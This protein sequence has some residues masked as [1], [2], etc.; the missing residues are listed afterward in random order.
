MVVQSQRLMCGIMAPF[1]LLEFGLLKTLIST[2]RKQSSDFKTALNQT[3]DG[4]STI[5]SP[6]ET[7]SSNSVGTFVK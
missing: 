1:D 2:P 6:S 7:G 4:S 3:K 5:I